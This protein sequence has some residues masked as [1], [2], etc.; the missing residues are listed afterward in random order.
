MHFNKC[1]TNS[2][3]QGHRNHSQSGLSKLCLEK[4]IKGKR[5]IG[6][7]A[8]QWNDNIKEWS[9]H[10]LTALNRTILDYNLNHVAR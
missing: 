6:K 7:Q 8:K 9:R 5:R 2:K 1:N 3:R 10:N 4:L